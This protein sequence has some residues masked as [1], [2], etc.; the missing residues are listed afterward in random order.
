MHQYQQVSQLQA[1]DEAFSFLTVSH[2][3]IKRSSQTSN[4]HLGSLVNH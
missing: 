1:I 4:L 3:I 2:I